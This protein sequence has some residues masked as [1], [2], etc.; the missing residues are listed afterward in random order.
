MKFNY[1]RVQTLHFN[2]EAADGS[3][4]AGPSVVVKKEKEDGK[5]C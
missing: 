2:G 4:A 3:A 5:P 1:N